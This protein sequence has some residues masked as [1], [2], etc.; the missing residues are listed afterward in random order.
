MLVPPDSCLA[1]CLD[2]PMSIEEGQT[3]SQPYIVAM[4]ISGGDRVLAISTSIGC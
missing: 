1:A 3:I 4:E 2:L